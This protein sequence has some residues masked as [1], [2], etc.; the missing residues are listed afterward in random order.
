MP[1]QVKAKKIGD[2][3]SKLVWKTDLLASKPYWNGWFQGLS[4]CF[5][6]ITCPKQLLL[7]NADRMDKELT[8]AQMQGKFKLMVLNDV[9]HAI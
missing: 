9:G 6:G 4:G 5:L 3:N 7:A 1:A 2:N 8:I